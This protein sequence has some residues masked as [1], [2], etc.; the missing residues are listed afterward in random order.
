MPV[1][2][3]GI[4][5]QPHLEDWGAIG[6]STGGAL[7]W[8]E[9]SIS[10]T[11]WRNPDEPDDPANLAELDPEQRHALEAEPRWPRPQ[12]LVEQVRRMRY[13]ILWECVRTR[14]SRRPGAFDTIESV[15]AAHVNHVLVN[16]FRQTRVVSSHPPSELDSPVYERCVDH[17]IPVLVDG[18]VLDGSRIDTD[19]DVY[20]VGVELGAHTV[21]TAA[22]PRDALPHVEVAF[23][24]RPI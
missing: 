6:V 9:V 22:I 21:V 2:V 20:G 10:Y 13:P 12:W 7:D 24:V 11:L 18:A 3:V 16:Q 1:P 19:P 8:C 4:T 23:A 15:L 5:S 14:W 17:G